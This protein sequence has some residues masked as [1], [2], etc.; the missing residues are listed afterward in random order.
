MINLDRFLSGFDLNTTFEDCMRDAY[1]LG[2]G[3]IAV[4][5]CL[6]QLSIQH[7]QP[8]SAAVD[9]MLSQLMSLQP[10]HQILSCREIQ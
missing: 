10:I 5:L 3:A 9:Y 1:Q 6:D 7:P 8:L 4:H 2:S